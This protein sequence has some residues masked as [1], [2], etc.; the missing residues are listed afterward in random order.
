MVTID[1]WWLPLLHLLLCRLL[2][3]AQRITFLTGIM[4]AIKEPTAKLLTTLDCAKM[5]E[6]LF[7]SPFAEDE[8][9]LRAVLACLQTDYRLQDFDWTLLG[10]TK[11]VGCS[12]R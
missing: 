3:C 9:F 7:P 6:A 5:R 12:Q 4:T 11:Q 1:Q 8:R 10:S 2:Y